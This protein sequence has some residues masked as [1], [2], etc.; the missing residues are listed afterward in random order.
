MITYMDINNHDLAEIVWELQK[1][2]YLVEADYIGTMDI[3]PL[4]ETLQELRDCGET[5]IGFFE[6]G[7]LAGVLSYKMDHDIMDIHRLMV[8]P[9][10]FRRGIGKEL[11]CYLE[12][13]HLSAREMTVSTGAK[14]SPAINLYLKLG[15][16]K[17]EER[18]YGDVLVAHFK[19]VLKR[20]SE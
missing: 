11:I 9:S 16:E 4:K 17:L 8:H 10:F 3:P 1:V 20:D 14:N 2:S 6:D 5:F 15:F 12:I 19:K 13:M 18:E 7:V